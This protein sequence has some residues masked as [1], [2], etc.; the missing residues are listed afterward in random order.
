[1]SSVSKLRIAKFVSASICVAAAW[2][3]GATAA[4]CPARLRRRRF[5]LARRNHADRLELRVQQHRP[6]SSHSSDRR[7]AAPPALGQTSGTPGGGTQE[8]LS[9]RYDD[10]RFIQNMVRANT[11][12]LMTGPYHF[13]R[14]DILTNTGADEADHFIQMAGVYMRPGYMLPMY[15]LEAGQAERTQQ[16]LA[17]FSLDFSNR[18]YEVMKIRPSIYASGNYFNDLSAASAATRNALAQPSANAPSMVSPAFPVFCW[19]SLP[20]R[21]RQSI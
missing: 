16:E 14:P 18:I 21:Q 4:A 20:G 9:R 17:Q 3:C 7:A 19:R 8:T 15:D 13:A 10:S 1:M 11:A 6:Q 5:V 12:G 2:N